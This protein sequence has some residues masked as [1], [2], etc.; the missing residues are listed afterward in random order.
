M[1]LANVKG[2]IYIHFSPKKCFKYSFRRLSLFSPGSGRQS[3]DWEC[4]GGGGKPQ[5]GGPAKENKGVQ[6]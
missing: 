5:R 2:E 4:T 1:F 3:R 6:G